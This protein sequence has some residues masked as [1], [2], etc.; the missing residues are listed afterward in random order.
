MTKVR[1]YCGIPILITNPSYSHK[2]FWPFNKHG[3]V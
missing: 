3:D 1:T 2:N